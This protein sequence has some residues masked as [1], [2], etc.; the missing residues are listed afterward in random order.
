M[1]RRCLD[2][3]AETSDI[4]ALDLALRKRGPNHICDFVYNLAQAFSRFYDKCHILREEDPARRAS[5]LA[6]AE[7]CLR[8][9]RLALDLL[10]I[11]VPE[12]M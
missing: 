7:L 3:W 10:A 1:T 2:R 5:W 11:E 8:Q 4:K 6:L 9:F 12:R